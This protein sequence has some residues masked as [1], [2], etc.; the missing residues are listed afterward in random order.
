MVRG[1]ALHRSLFLISI[2]GYLGQQYLVIFYINYLVCLKLM[3]VDNR[4]HNMS[5]IFLVFIL[6]ASNLI[7]YLILSLLFIYMLCVTSCLGNRYFNFFIK[8]TGISVLSES[9]LS[10]LILIFRSGNSDA[11]NLAKITYMP[12]VFW[13]VI[14]FVFSLILFF[15]LFFDNKKK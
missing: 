2:S 10:P 1:I 7:T 3:F 11:S 9:L 13:I 5:S 14:W 8:L 4:L 6:Y 12:E 15:L